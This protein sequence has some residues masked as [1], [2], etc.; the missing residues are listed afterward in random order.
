MAD[1]TSIPEVPDLSNAKE[2]AGE[3]VVR[4]VSDTNIT[5]KDIVSGL[6]DNLPPELFNKI[7]KFL[8]IG[9]YFL[10]GFFA[11]ILFK[12]IGQILSFRD[13]RNLRIIA[14]QTKEINSKLEKKK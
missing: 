2:I 5:A 3:I 6:Y 10:V 7:S 9:T 11:Y 4:A 1:I 12:I 13:S 8:D 14:E